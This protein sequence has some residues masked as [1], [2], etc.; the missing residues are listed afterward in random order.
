MIKV[1]GMNLRTILP[2]SISRDDRVQLTADAISENINSTSGKI[3]SDLI[4]SRIDG[5]EDNVL[6]ALAWQF[7]MDIYDS[8]LRQESKSALVKGSV[9]YHRYKGTV[10]SLE[11]AVK[12]VSDNSKVQEWFTYS[13]EPF[14]FKIR[15]STPFKDA[16]HVKRLYKAIQDAKNVR[17]WLDEI[18]VSIPVNNTIFMGVR[19]KDRRIIHVYQADLGKESLNDSLYIGGAM[20][21]EETIEFR[22]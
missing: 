11:E 2:L 15:T 6:D 7:H 14:H 8:S 18:D 12:A 4:Y 10:F 21:I 13:G 19:R 20:G 5:A 9:K 1:Y 3:T 22:G 17:S 16:N